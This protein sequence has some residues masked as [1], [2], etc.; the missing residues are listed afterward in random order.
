MILVHEE[1]LR[2][3]LEALRDR[4]SFTRIKML[5]D[6]DNSYNDNPIGTLADDYERAQLAAAVEQS[7]RRLENDKSASQIPP[8]AEGDSRGEGNGTRD[9]ADRVYREEEKDS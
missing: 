5:R 4:G 8:N 7:D 2:Q 9:G 3:V 1:A 6:I